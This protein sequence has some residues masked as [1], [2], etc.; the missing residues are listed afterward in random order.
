MMVYHKVSL[1]KTFDSIMS[2]GSFCFLFVKE[3]NI[4]AP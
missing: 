3:G 4:K 2:R 1:D